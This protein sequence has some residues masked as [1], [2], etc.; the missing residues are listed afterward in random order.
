MEGEIHSFFKVAGDVIG[1]KTENETQ[2][3]T[4]DNGRHRGGMHGIFDSEFA[5]DAGPAFTVVRDDVGVA[6]LYDTHS[7]YVEEAGYADDFCAIDDDAP[8]WTKS[9]QV[10]VAGDDE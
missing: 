3:Q 9:V 7:C 6:D 10:A 8:L 2:N 4:G 5:P 1:M